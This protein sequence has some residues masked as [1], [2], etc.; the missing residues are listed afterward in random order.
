MSLTPAQQLERIARDVHELAFDFAEPATS[1]R[2]AEDRIARVE[3]L[4]AALRAVVRGNAVT[5]A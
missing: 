1:R 5:T 4:A 2:E 3:D